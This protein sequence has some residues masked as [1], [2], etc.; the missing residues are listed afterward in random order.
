MNVDTT[1]AAGLYSARAVERALGLP[2]AAVAPLIA[3]LVAAGL[4]APSGPPNARRFTWHDLTLLR[5]AH[6]LRI[7]KVPP[8]K[9][10]G[11]LRRL[12]E[13]LPEALP[14]SGLRISAAGAAVTVRERGRQWEVDSGQL[15]LDFELAPAGASIALFAPAPPGSEANAAQ[16]AFERGAALDPHEA[17]AAEVEYRRALMLDPCLRDACANLGALLCEAGRCAEAVALYEAALAHCGEVA[18]IHFNRAIALE[19]MGD[20][21]AA[22][23][24]YERCL[25]LDAR[26]ADAHWNLAV[27]HQRGGDERGALRHF[28]AFRRLERARGAAS[29]D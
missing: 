3:A 10:V 17:A 14:L 9:V 22:R 25:A 12:K 29:R 28:S 20:D 21:A 13:A 27:L 4:I 1:P 16:A 6:A 15:L 7:A 8:R 18:V 19:D 23:A 11:A 2:R 26:F 24:A 5:T